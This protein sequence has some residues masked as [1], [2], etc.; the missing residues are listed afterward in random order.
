MKGGR[1]GRGY[2]TVLLTVPYD[3]VIKVEKAWFVVVGWIKCRPGCWK[4][5]QPIP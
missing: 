2:G 4:K 5:K 3:A 1:D